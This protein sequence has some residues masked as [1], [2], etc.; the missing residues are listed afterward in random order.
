MYCEQFLENINGYPVYENLFTKDDFLT[1]TSNVWEDKKCATPT[2]S[3][4]KG[5]LV[6]SCETPGAECVYE[7]R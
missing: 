1:T 3:Y 5:R 6:F 2:I 4:D 7:L